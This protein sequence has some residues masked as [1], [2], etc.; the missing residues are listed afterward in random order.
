MLKPTSSRCSKSSIQTKPRGNLSSHLHERGVIALYISNGIADKELI[1]FLAEYVPS[2]LEI[3]SEVR[4]VN[5]DGEFKALV[6]KVESQQHVGLINYL[7]V[8]EGSVKAGR[9]LQI[10]G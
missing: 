10:S 2:P 5:S 7:K 9:A 6:F 8:F 3:S 4:P 1:E